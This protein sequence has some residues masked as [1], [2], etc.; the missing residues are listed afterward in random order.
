MYFKYDVKI[1][2]YETNIMLV[3]RKNVIVYNYR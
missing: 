3:F 2:C 1:T